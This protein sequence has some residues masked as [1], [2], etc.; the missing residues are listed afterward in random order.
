MSS[1]YS[2][3]SFTFLGERL[4]LELVNLKVSIGMKLSIIVPCYNEEQTI[5]PFFEVT[6]KYVE[7]IKTD[8]EFFF[9]N[10]GSKD[11]TLQKIIELK[12][13]YPTFNITILDFSRNFGKEAGILA[14]LKDST[15]DYVV[16]MDADLQDPPNL[17]LPMLEIL[18][19]KSVV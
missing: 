13:A 19:R 18:D 14:G 7:S 15:G 5:F 6:S 16:T 2:V 17:L 3:L 1:Y 10:D 4:K 8:C 11:K 12:N 9:V